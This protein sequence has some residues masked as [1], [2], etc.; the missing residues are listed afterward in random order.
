MLIIFFFQF[1]Y[2]S[3]DSIQYKKNDLIDF[4]LSLYI[5]IYYGLPVGNR[6]YIIISISKLLINNH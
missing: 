3:F 5:I 2:F 6:L 1:S 4:I